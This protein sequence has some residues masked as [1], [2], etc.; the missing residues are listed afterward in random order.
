MV[1]PKSMDSPRRVRVV[2]LQQKI[3][4]WL[5][6]SACLFGMLKMKAFLYL[7]KL[8]FKLNRDFDFKLW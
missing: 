4:G 7:A 3:W 2:V 6:P 8:K 5:R 1:V